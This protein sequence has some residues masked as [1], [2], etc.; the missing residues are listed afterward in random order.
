VVFEKKEDR[1][2]YLADQRPHWIVYQADCIKAIADGFGFHDRP[3]F[4][5]IDPYGDPWLIVDAILRNSHKL[6]DRFAI[7]INDGNRVKIRSNT[8][9][10]QNSLMGMV[11]QF[12]NA[13][14]YKKYL[15]CCYWNM[16]VKISAMGYNIEHWTGYYCGTMDNMT[17]YSAVCVKRPT[18]DP[19]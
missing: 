13:N 15:E 18:E 4:F 2:Y 5:D 14:I 6:P 16:T 1:C 19:T 10:T 8:A 12:G 11:S 7:V 3:N 9:W 17:H